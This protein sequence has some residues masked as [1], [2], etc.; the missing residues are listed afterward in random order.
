MTSVQAQ[1]A[2]RII[3]SC[4]QA[5]SVTGALPDACRPLS[6]DSGYAAQLAFVEHSGEAVVG[7]KIAATSRA[8]QRH[9]NVDGPIAGRLLESRVHPN[10]VILQLGTNRMGVAEAEF[11]FVLG[12]SLP[13]REIAYSADEA[14]A[15]VASVH[16]AIEVPDSRFADF[17]QAGG[18]QLVADN[19][20]A[21]HFVLGP[22]AEV[23]PK[24]ID[25]ITHPVRLFIDG[26]EVTSGTG[27][28]ALGDP[29]TA[30]AW[31]AN[32]H[33]LQ[34]VALQSGDIVTTGVCGQPSAIKPGNHIIADFGVLGAAEATLS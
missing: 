16:P 2:G 12:D 26:K 13:A 23:D 14:L 5:G 22:A 17:V 11:A 1:E 27:A 29:R 8:G 28:D 9:I 19:A 21:S 34:G 18:P 32:N 24:T 10:L 7:W 31:I 30:L 4:W 33:A 15:A 25:F 6:L 20:C 3:H